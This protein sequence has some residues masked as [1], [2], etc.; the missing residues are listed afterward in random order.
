MKVLGRSTANHSECSPEGLALASW[1]RSKPLR[2]ADFWDRSPSILAGG[3]DLP[4]F[5]VQGWGPF[6]VDLVGSTKPAENVRSCLGLLGSPRFRL[7]RASERVRNRKDVG[8]TSFDVRKS[9]RPERG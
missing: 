7:F 6:L 9:R 5:R 1:G 8:S 2:M 3:L 4:T